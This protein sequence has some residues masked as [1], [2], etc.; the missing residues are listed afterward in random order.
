MAEHEADVRGVTVPALSFTDV[1]ERI[2]GGE[3]PMFVPDDPDDDE[4][5][6]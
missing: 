5:V 1:L 4:P 2:A 3:E 6:F